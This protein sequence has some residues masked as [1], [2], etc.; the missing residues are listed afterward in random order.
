MDRR[1]LLKA[2]AVSSGALA[3]P[4][5]EALT[6][7]AEAAPRLGKTL[8]KNMSVPWG[9]AFL[10]GGAALVGERDSGKVFRVGKDGGKHLVDR[11]SVFSQKA[12]FG[13]GGLLGLALSPTFRRDRW[14]YAYLSTR[15][16]NRIVRMK[17]ANGTLGRRHLVLAGIPM[18]V[19]HNGGGLAFGEGGLLFAS[20]GDGEDTANAQNKNSLGG[21]I[22]RLTPDGEVPAGNPFGNYTWSYGHRNPE[23]ITFDARGRLW[24]SEFG[25]KDKDELNRIRRGANYGWPFVEGKDGAGGYRDPLAQWDTDICSPSGVA[26]AN[27]RA[28]LGALRGQCLWSVRLDGPHRGRKARWFQGRFGRIRSVHRAPDGALWMTT[29][30]RDGRGTPG[31]VDDRIIRVR[32]P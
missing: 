22:L 32:L 27:G 5:G 13:E 26:V 24:S 11:L 9:I 23:G 14:V 3:L 28:W 19:H 16:D 25:E 7:S 29:S 8:A 17:Y 15:S 12:N 18:S 21:K 30:N 6:S 31:P 4:L 2:G 20:T 1:T 10:P